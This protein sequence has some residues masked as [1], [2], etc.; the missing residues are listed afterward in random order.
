M[1]VIVLVRKI[2]SGLFVIIQIIFVFQIAGF[3][4][5]GTL[6]VTKSGRVF[7]TDYN[8]WK[9]IFNGVSKKLKELIND[10]YKIIV[11]SN[12]AGIG[13]YLIHI[14]YYNYSTLILAHMLFIYFC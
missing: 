2:Y 13:K 9:I 8:D 11:F 3:D 10:N 12:Q 7:A 5:D 1:K 14:Y 4:M 6:I